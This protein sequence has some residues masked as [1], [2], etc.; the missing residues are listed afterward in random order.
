MINS[1]ALSEYVSFV[2]FCQNIAKA[3]LGKNKQTILHLSLNIIDVNTSPLNSISP[4]QSAQITYRY[5]NC[6]V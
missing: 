4:P 1:D 5:D 3:V 6:D 2:A